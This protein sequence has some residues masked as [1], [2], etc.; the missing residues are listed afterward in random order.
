MSA[1][2]GFGQKNKT[3]I[4]PGRLFF[5]DELLSIRMSTHGG[6]DG[7]GGGRETE[8][9]G[10][11]GGEFQEGKGQGVRNRGET[12]SKGPRER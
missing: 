7:V 6:R 12:C 4:L 3:E 10:G 1:F 8:T 2:P 11:G 9:G 5:L